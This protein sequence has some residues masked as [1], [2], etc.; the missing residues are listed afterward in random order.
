MDIIDFLPSYPNIDDNLF[1]NKL[2][3]KYEFQSLKLDSIEPVPTEQGILMKHQQ[4]LSRYMS[5][6]TLYDSMLVVH[7]MGTGKSCTAVGVI[8]QILK[9]NRGINKAIYLSRGP[10]LLINFREEYVN[11]CINNVNEYTKNKIPNL[12]TFTFQTFAKNNNKIVNFSEYN[13]TIFILDEVH[14]LREQTTGE[15]NVYGFFHNLLHNVKN[16]KILL[17]SGTPMKDQASEIISLM[18][19]ILPL[20]EQLKVKDIFEEQDV[21]TEQGK[22]ILRKAMKGRVSYLKSMNNVLVNKQLNG[23]IPNGMKYFKLET[24]DM[25]KDSIQLKQYKEDY[26]NDTK[27][28]HSKAVQSILFVAPNNDINLAL[29]NI[30]LGK[31]IQDKL[32]ILEKYSSKYAASVRTI[33]QGYKDKKCIFVYNRLVQ[34]KGIILFSKILKLFNF[35]QARMRNYQRT[36]VC[37]TNRF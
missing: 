33:I 13:N 4:I 5:S 31:T 17:L 20:N 6:N 26:E 22:N 36:T 7:E 24:D 9:E 28:L 3:S 19:L 29:K 15:E 2:N 11:K 10:D 16:C 35:K 30:G 14:N 37:T 21:I 12:K 27:G 8:E 18:N 23:S 1:F 25:K 34:D 32:N